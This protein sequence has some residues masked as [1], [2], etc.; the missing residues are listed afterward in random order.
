MAKLVDFS[1]L[2]L[3]RRIRA[4]ERAAAVNHASQLMMIGLTRS[5]SVA[6]VGARVGVSARTIDR[7]IET[8]GIDRVSEWALAALA[9]PNVVQDLVG[10]HK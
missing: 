6:I 2:P 3:A 8:I 10:D 9:G 5:A 4:A 1:S 7:W